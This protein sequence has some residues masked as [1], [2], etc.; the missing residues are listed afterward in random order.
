MASYSVDDIRNIA[1]V[2]HGSA[3][4]T[5]LVDALLHK[6]GVINAIGSIER[7]T[8]VSDFDPQE[9]QH[10]H[11]LESAIVSMDYHGG[12]INL[13]DTPGYP[14]FIGRALTILPATETC[15][16]VINAQN[17]IETMTTKMMDVAKDREM[18]RLI[19]INKIDVDQVN[20]QSLLEDIKNAFG[21]ECLPLNLPAQ[22]GN[23]V[24]DCFFKS[25][26]DDTDFS[27]VADAHTQIIDQIIELDEDL[28]EI[29]LEQGEEIT[30]EQLH[31][32]FEKALRDGHLIPVCFVSAIT[33]AGI[34]ELLDIFA[35][36]MPNPNEG[37][38]PQFIKGEGESAKPIVLESDPDAHALAHVFK[39]SIDPYIGKVGFFRIHQGTCTRNSQLFISDGRKT[40]KVGHLL[41]FQGKKHSEIS[42]GMP[43]DICAVAKV[44]DIHFDAVLH[45][46][47]DEDHIH[48]RSV[49]LPEPMYG[50]AIE[51]KTHGDE[52]KIADALHKLV[53]EDQSLTVE[54]NVV[55]NE[56]VIRG[57]GELH[58]RM[59]LEKLNDQYHIEVKTRPPRIAYKETITVNAE[60]HYRHKKQTGGAGQFGEV[61]LRIKPLPQGEGF[62]FVNEV[63]GGAIPKQFIPAIEKGIQQALAEGVI[64]GY[65]LL[66][67]KVTIYEGKFHAVDSKEIAFFTA[68]KK[69]FVDAVKKAQAVV[70]EPVVEITISTPSEAMGDVSADLASKHGRITNTT[71]MKNNMTAINGLVPLSELDSY[72]S[73]LKSMTGGEGLFSISFSHHVPVSDRTQKQLVAAYKPANEED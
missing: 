39:V 61:F 29:Y 47:H 62:V 2:G 40:F 55:L 17:G 64:A 16:V 35:K 60:G 57:L 65:P 73:Q 37:N 6:S 52:Q 34:D 21:N 72:Q 7:G 4:K 15:A 43:G 14:D 25:T 54:H 23:K 46:S 24:E 5:L 53:A 68:G 49:K 27:T 18:E 22:N 45:D 51:T 44:D 3:G 42:S 58:L 12:H 36:L 67:I 9:K 56:L 19:I 41:K 33:G 31:E 32:P 13:I 63:V 11:S 69:A 38:P 70:L 71:V 1:L 28:M 30:P 48:L 8:T 26:G 66:D 50:L 20:L 59:I 10:Q